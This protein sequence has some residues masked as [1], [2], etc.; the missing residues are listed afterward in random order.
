[1]AEGTRR[2]SENRMRVKDNKREIMKISSRRNE[3]HLRNSRKQEGFRRK[4]KEI[5]INKGNI[6][7]N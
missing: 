2:G 1:M 7:G 5:K 6:M 4:G 3:F